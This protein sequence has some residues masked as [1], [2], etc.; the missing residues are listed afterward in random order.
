MYH[1]I[2]TDCRKLNVRKE[3]NEYAE[4]VAVVDAYDKIFVDF[5]NSEGDYYKV[6]TTSGV[7]GYC[8]KAHVSKLKSEKGECVASW[9]SIP[10]APFGEEEEYIALIPET[11][12]TFTKGGYQDPNSD[13]KNTN[14]VENQEYT[15]VFDGKEYPGLYLRYQGTA[16]IPTAGMTEELPFQFQNASG[17]YQFYVVEP[18]THTV[19]VYKK[20]KV[21]TPIPEKYIPDTVAGVSWIELNTS[22]KPASLNGVTPITRVAFEEAFASGIVRI[23]QEVSG[24]GD[25][26]FGTLIG[27]K[28]NGSTAS[29]ILNGGSAAALVDLSWELT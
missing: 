14:F 6:E 2:V 1:G 12:V 17:G 29:V 19:A 22:S 9:D 7:E 27:Y 26:F 25:P 20:E 24:Y 10:D 28:F 21:V 13:F 4:I 23:R 8:L 5:E 15:I 16:V 3:P 18:G 11:S